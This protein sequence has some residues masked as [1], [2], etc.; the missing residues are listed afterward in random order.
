MPIR[1]IATRYVD[2]DGYYNSNGVGKLED[3][4]LIFVDLENPRWVNVCLMGGMQ[5]QT[6]M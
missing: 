5:W 4:L 1:Y 6:L 3:R 2:L